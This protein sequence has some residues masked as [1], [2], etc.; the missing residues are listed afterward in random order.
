MAYIKKERI[1]RSELEYELGEYQK[2]RILFLEKVLEFEQKLY[3]YDK[4]Y[5]DN[6]IAENNRVEHWQYLRYFEEKFVLTPEQKE[7]SSNLRN[8]F[9]HNEYP[10]IMY[11]EDVCSEEEKI[12]V[13]S[14]L[15]QIGIKLYEDMVS[16]IQK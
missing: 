5:F 2:Q 1:S 15:A 4:F 9:S 8:K 6:I 7:Q 12:G 16:Q 10:E 14:Q 13:A 3:A 11:F